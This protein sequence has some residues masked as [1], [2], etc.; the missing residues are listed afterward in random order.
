MKIF[1]DLN[2]QNP[3]KAESMAQVVD[4]C[5]ASVRLSSKL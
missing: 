4:A 2:S 1:V 3:K 5:L